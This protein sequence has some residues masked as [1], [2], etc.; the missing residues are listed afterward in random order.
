MNL[1]WIALSLFFMIAPGVVSADEPAPP[2]QTQI[3]RDA[4]QAWGRAHA[5][6]EEW[7]DSCVACTKARCSTAGIACT[8]K[9]TICR[10][11]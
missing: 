5:D 8:P 2:P 3:E 7:S 4:V 11:K 10:A 6:C 1:K 9:E